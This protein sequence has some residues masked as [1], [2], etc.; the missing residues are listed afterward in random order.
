[1]I[2]MLSLYLINNLFFYLI[3]SSSTEE[4]REHME[5]IQILPPNSIVSKI[6]EIQVLLMLMKQKVN[7]FMLRIIFLRKKQSTKLF[8]MPLELKKL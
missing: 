6:Q 5:Y 1:M 7:F 4:N 3:F 8:N 2:A